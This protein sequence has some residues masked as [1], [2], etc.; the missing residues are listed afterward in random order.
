MSRVTRKQRR[1]LAV[2]SE[3]QRPAYAAV[4]IGIPWGEVCDWYRSSARFA[5]RYDRIDGTTAAP[6]KW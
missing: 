1:F 5:A 3:T 6:V 4:H 2:F